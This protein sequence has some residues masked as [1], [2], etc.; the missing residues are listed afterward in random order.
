MPH[1]HPHGIS[2]LPGIETSVVALL[3]LAVALVVVARFKRG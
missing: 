2:M 1:S 3:A